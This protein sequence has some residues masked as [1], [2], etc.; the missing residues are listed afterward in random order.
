MTTKRR[1]LTTIASVEAIKPDPNGQTDTPDTKVRGL[2][3]RTTPAGGKSWTLRYRNDDGR[4]QRLNLGRYPA[5][6]LSVARMAAN[7][8][9]AKIAAG[10]DPAG[11]KRAAKAAGK[12]GT[13]ATVADLIESYLAASEKARHRPNARPKRPGTLAL[14]RYYFERHIKSRFGKLAIERLSRSEVQRFLDELDDRAPST[15]LRCSAVLRQAYNYGI[16][17][18]IATAN[19]A[20]FVALPAP[21]QRA[22]VLNDAELKSI[23]NGVEELIAAGS[24]AAL[25]I[26]LEMLTLQRGGEVAGIHAREIDRKA[27][28]W[29]LPGARVKNHRIHVVPLSDAA[30]NPFPK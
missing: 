11:T 29:T 27:R 23:W 7:D 20:Q 28:L 13:A 18:E 26:R 4:Q 6:S 21:N 9:L 8:A 2:A 22:P 15:A 17:N 24:K 30:L 25:A 3:L 19:P 10:K 1:K 14:E 5:V 12:A 16:R